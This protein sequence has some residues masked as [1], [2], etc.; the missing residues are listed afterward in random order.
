MKISI[1]GTRGI[2]NKYGGF[3]QLACYLGEGLTR[4]GHEVSVY[5]PDHHPNKADFWNGV[6][7]IRKRGWENRVGRFGQFLFDLLC[8]LDTRKRRPDIVLELGY[9][10]NSL[11][12]WLY[13]PDQVVVT[14]IDGLEW[15]RRQHSWIVQKYLLFAEKVAVNNSDCVISDSIGIQDYVKKKYRLDSVYIPYGA[16]VFDSPDE[17][18]L[19]RYKLQKYRFNMLI[20][21]FL[22]ENNI[23]MILEGVEFSGRN[24]KMLVI[25]DYNNKFGN[26]LLDRF[27]SVESIEF[28]GPI[29]DI[30]TLNNMRYYSNIY[31]HGHSVGGTNPSLLE[32]M[33]SSSLVCA[34]DNPF[35][36][37]ILGDDGFYFRD[38]ND[39]ASFLNTLS[40]EDHCE[41][42]TSNL[43]KISNSYSWDNIVDQ[44]LSVFVKYANRDWD[45]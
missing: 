14:N 2:P 15:S 36:R 4:I 38:S 12:F 6:T 41:K 3:E 23:E 26:K 35:N 27:K 29:Y 32:A 39:V 18:I 8:I 45:N 42:I 5:N 11:W 30:E 24:A 13:K 20:A 16:H 9:T 43:S 7:I 21:R 25:G 37:G 44:Y 1:L 28:L 40:K 17:S 22:P 10:S 31:F 34:H 19:S 33:A